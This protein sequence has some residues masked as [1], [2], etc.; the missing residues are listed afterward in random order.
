MNYR[1]AYHAGNHADVL[2]HVVLARVIAHMK[3]KDKPFRV[4][5]AHAGAGVY[6]LAGIEAGKT[7]EWEGGIGKL[8]EPFSA[9]AEDLLKPYRHV[10]AA[11]NPGGGLRYY[12]GSPELALRLMR[13]QDRLLANELHPQDA[14]ALERQ[15]LHD[16]RCDVTA[17]DAETC[18]KAR[19]PPPERRGVILIDPPYEAKNEAEKALRMLA[20][21]LRRFAQGVFLLWYPLKADCTAETILAAVAEMGVPATLKAELRVREA[22]AAGGLAGSGL[23][24]LNAPWKLDEELRLLAPALA[25]RLGLGDWGRATVA[26]LVEPR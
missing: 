16:P 20:H 26:W 21:G 9:E 7:G 11:L 24:I 25:E 23:A 1:H 14:V 3:K 4:I 18:L 22:F 10:I 13:P 17:M 19:L 6:D 15:Y 5:D 8:A 2:K 12:P